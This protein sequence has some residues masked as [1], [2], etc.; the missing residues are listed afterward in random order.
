MKIELMNDSHLEKILKIDQDAFQRDEPRTV[1]NL[2]GLREGDPEG[3]FV[4]MDG[5]DL[6][7]YSFNKTMGEEGY[8]GPVGIQP[9]LHGRGWGQ[10]V[11][12]CSLDYLKSRCNVIGLEVRPELGS[13]IGLYHKMG[14]HSAFPSLILEVPE[15]FKIQKETSEENEDE[16]R[17]RTWDYN[18]DIYSEM[19]ENR[20]EK[21][22]DK[23]ELWTLHDLKGISYRKDLELILAGGGEIIIISQDTEPMG[24]L[25]YY[26]IVFLHLWGAMK[27]TAYQKDFLR[28][29]LHFF[30]NK[31]PQ[32][33]VLLEVNTRYQDLVNILLDEGLIIRKSVNRMLLNGFEG[34]Y[35]EKSPDFVMRAW[36][37]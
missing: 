18:L 22:L 30:R 27:P 6:V 19:P 24:F 9:S 5:N 28:K 7:G 36:H 16:K 25:A 35:L 11:I 29:G 2:K 15:N 4:L 34:E 12:Q 23:I 13:N 32:G 33:E 14:F 8:L 1:S 17:C 37:A 3:C 20:R 10:K 26:S 21:L 31:N